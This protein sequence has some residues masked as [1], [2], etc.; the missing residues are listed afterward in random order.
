[1]GYVENGWAVD[2]LIESV[3][4]GAPVIIELRV[5]PANAAGKVP[6]G[7][8]TKDVL[9]AISTTDLYDSFATWEPD[10]LEREIATEIDALYDVR[11][12]GSAGHDD[13]YYAVW[14]QRYVEACQTTRTPFLALAERYPP[15]TAAQIRRVVTTARRRKLLLGRT[16]GRPG[17][18]LS[19]KAERLAPRP[20]SPGLVPGTPKKNRPTK[21]GRTQ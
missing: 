3:R 8:V 9:R 1:V 12:P 15:N 7:G 10:L 19:A 18:R 4:G 17:G 20:N 14:A 11:R 2:A 6:P 5:R 13:R 16:Q 21:K